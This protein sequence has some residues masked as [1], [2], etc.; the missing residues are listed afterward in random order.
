MRR[1]KST[2]V[3]LSNV[4]IL[5]YNMAWLDEHLAFAGGKFITHVPPIAKQCAFHIL[6][7]LGQQ[8]SVSD[9]NLFI[10]KYQTSTNMFCIET[11][12]S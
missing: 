11:E 12:I 10:I 3:M 4:S 8:D 6:F 1:G 9:K 7:A 2:E 5:V